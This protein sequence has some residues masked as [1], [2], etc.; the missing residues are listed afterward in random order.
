MSLNVPPAPKLFIVP[1]V[2]PKRSETSGFPTA[3]SQ[4]KIFESKPVLVPMA[5]DPELATR[6]APTFT[7]VRKLPSATFFV[8]ALLVTLALVGVLVYAR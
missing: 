2:I 8:F 3:Q 6:P 5:Q 4:I 7:P 1:R